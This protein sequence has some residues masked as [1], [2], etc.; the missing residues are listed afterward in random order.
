[1]PS[2]A[3]SK[4]LSPFLAISH[5][6]NVA[7]TSSHPSKCIM[8]S[9]IDE[10]TSNLNWDARTCSPST[11][12]STPTVSMIDM[13]PFQYL[14]AAWSACHERPY[15]I[16]QDVELCKILL[17]LNSTLAIH[18]FQTVA[19]DI[20]NMYEHSWIFIANHLQSIQHQLHLTLNDGH[21][22]I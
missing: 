11:P 14:M 17:M 18:S 15:A 12:T 3:K 16:I 22:Q 4:A 13:G 19:H 5:H 9:P 1:M 8:C 21:L 2:L 6:A 10:S 20:S 7:S